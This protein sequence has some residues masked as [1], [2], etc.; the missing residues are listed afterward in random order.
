MK[1]KLATILVSNSTPEAIN[2]IIKI[3]DSQKAKTR[4][5][6]GM[7]MFFIIVFIGWFCIHKSFECAYL[8]PKHGAEK[9]SII[10]Y[11][12]VVIGIQD[13]VLRGAVYFKDI[14]N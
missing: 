8:K 9:D 14:K 5:A 7:L 10:Q 12:D 1:R 2:E 3:I 6:Y 11:K 4:M 13:S